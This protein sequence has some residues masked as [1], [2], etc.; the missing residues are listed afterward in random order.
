[1]TMPTWR[2]H[3]LSLAAIF[4]ALSLGV[5]IGVGLTDSGAVDTSQKDLVGSLQHDLNSLR[6]QNNQ[7][8]QENATNATFQEDSFPFIVGAQLQ[9]KRI[10]VIASAAA[11]GDLQRKLE[12]ALH[13]A[14]AEMVTTTILNSRFDLHAAAAKARTDMKNNPAF[15]AVDD[16][17]LITPIARELSREIGKG[18]STAMLSSLQGTLI[19]STSGSFNAPVDGVVII[20]RADDQQSPAYSEL[21]KQLALGLRSLSVTAVGCEPTDA[22]ISEIP[23]FQSAD[24]AS[25]DNLDSFI[26]QVSAVYALAGAHG[27]FGVKP[28]ADMLVPILKNA[29]QPPLRQ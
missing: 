13:A 21:E 4:L 9:G 8:S 28:T 7:L 23:L 22:P 20:T 16:N 27:A 6:G 5:L 18:G 3:L 10:A 15:S 11:G 24:V 14:G 17:A 2:Y 1:M 19:E 25:V 26:G 29:K 12:T